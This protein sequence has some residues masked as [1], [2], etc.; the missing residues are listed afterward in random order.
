MNIKVLCFGLS[1][2]AYH[3]I[4]PNDAWGQLPTTEIYSFEIKI[5]GD[6]E[7]VLSSPQLVNSFN[8][9]GY[10][11]QPGYAGADTWYISAAQDKSKFTDILFLDFKDMAYANFTFTEGISEFSPTLSLDGRSLYTVR[12]EK[13]L[14][15]QTLWQ[16]PVDKSGYGKNILPFL[17]NVG[18]FTQ[19]DPS[20]F[21]IFEV[22][23]PQIL[24]VYHVNTKDKKTV[25]Q[26]PGRCLKT[27]SSGQLIFVHKLLPDL[28]FL[29]SYDHLSS[30]TIALSQIKSED[31]EIIDDKLILCFDGTKLVTL[32]LEKDKD[33]RVVQDLSIYGINSPNRLVYGNGRLLVINSRS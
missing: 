8:R 15:T 16:Y 4:K 10:N 12:I 18:Y 5:E 28:Y 9:D 30:K 22:G 29:K 13:D 24:N 11:N 19:I 26:N 27:N 23:E 3:I 32:H 1:L 6:Y 25:V 31:F 33:W 20:H 2:I 17:K 14:K 21:A 7:L